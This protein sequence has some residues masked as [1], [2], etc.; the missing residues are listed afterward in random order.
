MSEVF[1]P[2]RKVLAAVALGGVL[3]VLG[4]ALSWFVLDASLSQV[5]YETRVESVS[6][7]RACLR[8]GVM[9]LVGD[10]L[11]GGGRGKKCT[12]LV[13]AR[14]T[15]TNPAP[16]ALSARVENVRA[17]ISGRAMASDA[18]VVPK[19][20]VTVPAGGK[21][22]QVVQFRADL[23]DLIAAASGMLLTKEVTIEVDAEVH[24]S[25]LWGLIGSRRSVHIE[26][27]LTVRDITAGF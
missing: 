2:G 7:S 13:A 3:L 14:V 10:L 6:P 17:R 8:G 1:S 12:V 11:G 26:K 21:A 20:A 4:L 22:S 15:V 5:R 27:A 18:I 9:G 23:G 25:G 24:V 16:L 19:A